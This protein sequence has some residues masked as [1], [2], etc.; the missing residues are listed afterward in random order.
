[1]LI[2]N[3][4]CFAFLH[5]FAQLQDVLV[6]DFITTFVKWVSFKCI[7][8]NYLGLNM[9]SS[10]SMGWWNALMIPSHK[11]DHILNIKIDHLT[12]ELKGQHVWARYKD[13]ATFE[14]FFCNSNF[15]HQGNGK[16]GILLYIC[17]LIFKF[18]NYFSFH[19]LMDALLVVYMQ[20]WLGEGL[21][22]PF[23]YTL[24]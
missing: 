10:I 5:H 18:G 21:K 20:Y 2:I 8:I 22:L 7:V 9:P 23:S 15:V 19:E 14:T 1:L 12:F 3:V 13:H 16:G 17:K 11:M 6:C 4:D 24:I